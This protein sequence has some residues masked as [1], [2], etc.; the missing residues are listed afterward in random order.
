MDLTDSQHIE[1][2]EDVCLRDFRP[3]HD[4]IKVFSYS[5]LLS[6]KLITLNNVRIASIVD[7][8]RFISR[9]NNCV[10]VIHILNFIIRY[11]GYFDI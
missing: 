7:I 10:L 8:L 5:T 2:D 6:M 4:A 3:D 1:H 11:S 9:I